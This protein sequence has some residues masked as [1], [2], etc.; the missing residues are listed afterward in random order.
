MRKKDVYARH[1]NDIPN[2][3]LSLEYKSELKP[4]LGEE[5]VY[6]SCARLVIDVL[7]ACNEVLISFSEPVERERLRRSKTMR[8]FAT[9]IDSSEVIARNLRECANGM[10]LTANESRDD[11]SFGAAQNE[12]CEALLNILCALQ[13]LYYV[14]EFD[15]AS[16][17]PFYAEGLCK[18]A[19]YAYACMKLESMNARGFISL[20]KN[21]TTHS[22]ELIQRI[23]SFQE[24]NPSGTKTECAGDLVDRKLSPSVPAA[25]KFIDR[26]SGFSFPPGP[27]GRPPKTKKS[28]KE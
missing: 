28:N 23:I 14:S 16:M 4:Y 21:R 1:L 9:L 5:N 22:K 25:L 13:M 19:G 27:R 15:S 26:S 6:Q 18:D 20:A 12:I 17:R 8:F 11:D 10:D 3:I 7:F 24:E 2:N